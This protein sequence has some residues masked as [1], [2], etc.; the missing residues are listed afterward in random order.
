MIY[1]LK[2]EYVCKISIFGLKMMMKSGLEKI[3]LKF[4][5]AGDYFLLLHKSSRMEGFQNTARPRD[6]RIL[7]PEKNREAQN[8]T[9]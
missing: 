6:T 8:R 5:H 1:V 2:M 3:F 4:L 9:L 7:G